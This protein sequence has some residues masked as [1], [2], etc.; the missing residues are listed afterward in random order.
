MSFPRFCCL[1]FSGIQ[2]TIK[3]Y[4]VASTTDDNTTWLKSFISEFFQTMSFS[5]IIKN[6]CKMFH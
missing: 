1:G 3:V 4:D 6:K 2:T 5:F